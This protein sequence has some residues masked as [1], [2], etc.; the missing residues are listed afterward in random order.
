MTRPC[1]PVRVSWDAPRVDWANWQLSLHCE[2]CGRMR[3][4]EVAGSI[5]EDVQMAEH[6]EQVQLKA[7]HAPPEVV[8]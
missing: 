8:L 2:G 5:A 7:L 4:L 6:V 1:Q 3:Q